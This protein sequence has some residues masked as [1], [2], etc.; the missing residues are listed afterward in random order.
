MNSQKRTD[1]WESLLDDEMNEVYWCGEARRY[2]VQDRLLST[3]VAIASSST[4]LAL[5][6]S[7]QMV[8]KVIACLATVVSIVHATFFH[9]GRLKQVT[10]LAARWKEMAIDYRLLW[11]GIESDD[12]VDVKVWKEYETISRREKQIDE[13]A[14]NIN[15]RR[16]MSAFNQVR[17]AR[18]FTHE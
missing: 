14:F 10:T 6:G 13:S 11:A 17:T 4:V 18:G 7:A 15:Q 1:I 16:L 9:T 5:V 12:V 2:G 8:G 3:T